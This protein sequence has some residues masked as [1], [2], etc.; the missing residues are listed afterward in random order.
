MTARRGRIVAANCELVVISE[1]GVTTA[2]PGKVDVPLHEG[3][4]LMV[5]IDP[6]RGSPNVICEQ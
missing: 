5:N 3:D 2:G 6:T 1:D 4:V